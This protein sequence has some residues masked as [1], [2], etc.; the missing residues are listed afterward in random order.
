M[1]EF[2]KQL[3]QHAFVKAYG[4][5]EILASEDVYT[6]IGITGE[7]KYAFREFP[8]ENK[9]PFTKEQEEAVETEIYDALKQ[10]D[11]YGRIAKAQMFE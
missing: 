7:D 1:Q 11:F 9:L 8:K 4:F 3:Q 10:N 2:V 5:K 6:L